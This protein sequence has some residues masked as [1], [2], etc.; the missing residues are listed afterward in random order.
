MNWNQGYNV[1]HG[2]TYGHYKEQDPVWMD[3]CA[4]LRDS[5]SVCPRA[6]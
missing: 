5:S 4:L 3:F 6:A 1:D 2:Y